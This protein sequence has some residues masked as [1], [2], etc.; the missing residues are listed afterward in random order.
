MYLYLD[1]SALVK[2]YIHE[3]G[4]NVVHQIIL[5]AETVAISVVGKV[6]MFSALSRTNR[7]V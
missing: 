7:I 6:E 2:R 4:S 3:L 1:T 5:K